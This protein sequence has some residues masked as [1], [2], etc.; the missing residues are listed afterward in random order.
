M[1]STSESRP[2]RLVSSGARL[3]VR[4]NAVHAPIDRRRRPGRAQELDVLGEDRLLEHLQSGAGLDPE[5]LDQRRA[6]RAVG[7]KGL[8]LAPRPIQREH[9][10]TTEALAKRVVGYP[11]LELPD[12]PRVSTQAPNP[13]RRA[14]RAPPAERL[15]TA[16][17]RPGRTTRS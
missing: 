10:L 13:H 12:Q 2:I 5:L 7:L 11:L 14:A 15:L 9:Q 16:R 3:P 6:R 8:R 4:A 1:R 17:A